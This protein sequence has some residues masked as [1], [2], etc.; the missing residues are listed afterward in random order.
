MPHTEVLLFREEEDVPLLTLFES[1]PRRARDDCLERLRL[2][3]QLGHELRRSHTDYLRD[4]IY[5]LRVKREGVNYRMLYFFHGRKAVVVSHG[6]VKQQATVPAREID[7]A[8][9]RMARFRSEPG[10]HTF[11][12]RK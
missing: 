3:E 5:E 4:E 10:K 8:A 1:I 9:E 12:P 7:R 6:I 2:L 11:G